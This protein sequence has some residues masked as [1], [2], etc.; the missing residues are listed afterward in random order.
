MSTPD[1]Q[2]IS[3]AQYSPEAQEHYDVVVVGGGITGLTLA[4][5]LQ[6]RS[7]KVLLAEA[8]TY[9]GGSISTQSREGF[10]WEEGPNSF[11]P[12]PALLNLIADVGLADQLVW[13]DRKLPRYVYWDRELIPVPLSP[14]AAITS[15][16]LTVGAKLRALQG[17]LGFVGYP[18]GREETVA[19][20]FTRQL[21]SE[22]VQ[23]LIVPFV[24]GVYAGD[25]DQ[26]SAVAAFH[27]IAS[28]EE[29]YGSLI[30]G[31]LQAPRPQP[32]PM[33][34]EIHPQP[35][36]GQLGNFVE[37][38]Q[39][40][41]ITI[42]QR[43]GRS[44]QLGWQAKT[45][46]SLESSYR[47]EFAT[48]DGS[49][50]VQARS[51]ALAIPAYR[52]AL[53]LE[54]LSHPAASILHQIPYAAVA[55]V[56]LGYPTHALPQPFQGFGHLIP[57]SQGL[58]TLG[59]IWSS[60]LFPGRAPEGYHCLLNFIGGATDL[61]YARQRGIPLVVDLSPEERIQQVHADLNQILLQQSVE[62]IVLGERVWKPA[63]PQYTLGHRQ[64]IADLQTCLADRPGL[65]ITG[66]FIE[67]VSLGDCVKQANATAAKI[68]SYLN[69]D[70]AVRFEA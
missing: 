42:A 59:T 10:R 52:A 57:R 20:F 47:L 37:G 60:C 15:P 39:Q 69:R 28:L 9:V 55:V 66:N 51:V 43:L 61:T 17:I 33:S 48:A 70:I 62:P 49:H 32:E 26:L 24:S 3:N 67:G 53:I 21:G 68:L 11:S 30:A 22:I 31:F 29:H 45:I 40:L 27:R 36:R 65:F 58:R 38:L 13:A 35:R 50:W 54:P 25:P 5:R 6:Q 46:H 14:P 34:P 2:P 64:R 7:L 23:K 1:L 18:P 63:I 56:A 12:A 19:E 4:W 44:I 41:P 8:Q 16:L